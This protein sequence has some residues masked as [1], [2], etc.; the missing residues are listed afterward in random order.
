V[1]EER[2]ARLKAV[3]DAETRIDAL[4][5]EVARLRT[6]IHIA[7]AMLTEGDPAG[8]LRQVAARVF[9]WSPRGHDAEILRLVADE[10][11]KAA[12]ALDVG[13]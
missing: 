10:I 6:V 2:Q 9:G 3:L 8:E 11:K 7:R 5:D 12:H 4:E 13:P 1:S